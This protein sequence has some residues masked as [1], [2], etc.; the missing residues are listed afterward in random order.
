METRKFSRIGKDISLLGFGLMRLPLLASGNAREID[1][2]MACRMV[3]R[4]IECGV[5]Y[6]DTAYVYHE[7]ESENLAGHA[8]SRHP[9]DSYN[10][11][12]KMPV[13]C[14]ENSGDLERIFAEQL[15]KCRVDHFDFYLLHNIGGES[16]DA[17]LKYDVYDFLR[18]KKDAGYIRNLGFSIH[19]APDVLAKAV[20][21]GEWD[22]AQIQLNYIDWDAI[23]SKRL[24]GILAENDIPAVIME[25]VRGGALANL[26]AAAAD[27]LRDFDPRA[28][29]ASWAIRYAASLPGVLTVLSGMT[30]PEQ[31]EDNL[32]TMSDFR[33]LSD[34]ERAVL[35]RAAAAFRASGTVPCTGCRYCM[36]CP[37]GV[38]IPRVFAMYNQYMTQKS[39]GF[40][41]AEIVLRNTYRTFNEGERP[42]N[43]VNC[44]AC[45]QHC[46]QGIDI[47]KFMREITELLA[48]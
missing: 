27:I 32:G 48:A 37:S 9:R 15:K 42:H 46:P 35:D 5:N 3:D 10:L 31:L 17:A 47:P 8:L 44:G 45:A 34:E 41:M 25:P 13:W 40:P 29:Q 16:Y 24:Y 43:C 6:F 39:A 4:A 12:T 14:L 2:D 20:T 22:F 28:S 23:E 18:K 38:D 33:P 30:R 36:D 19:D 11:A 1:Y 7:R 26:P 21:W